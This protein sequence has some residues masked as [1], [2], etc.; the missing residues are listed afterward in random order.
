M[1]TF[2]SPVYTFEP[3]SSPIERNPWLKWA[4]IIGVW[5]FIGVVY[6]APIYIEMRAEGM[7]HSAFKVF[8]WGILIWVAWAPFEPA[9]VWFAR[10][11]SLLGGAWKRSLPVH[12]PVF[13]ISSAVHSAVAVAI[14]LTVKPWDNMGTTTFWPRFLSRMQ[15]SFAGD[16]LVYGGI[17]GV[18]YAIDYYRKYQERE[19][20]ATQLENQLALAQL[21]SLRM[22]LHPHFLFNTLNGI[23]GLVRD[24]KNDAAVSMLVGLSDLLRHTL[25]HSD[26]QEVEL[27]EEINFIKLYL[28]IQ[29]MR[30]SDRLQI[31]FNIDPATS[32]A[33]VPNL[34]LQPL[35]ENALR[36]GIGRSADAGAITVSSKRE[37]GSLLITVA[38][39]GEGLPYDW[40]L[41][42]GSGIGLANT[43]A[44]LQQLYGENHRFDIHNG[45]SG[46][47][48]VEIVMP[49]KI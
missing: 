40:Q 33:L 45:D 31:N 1:E 43:A 48:E 35:L 6:T 34:L 47:V 17:V 11:F 13:L 14:V 37:N 9:I 5:A 41:K 28:G 42:T 22:Q 25:E 23:V 32:K 8:T 29:Q 18:C 49:L 39:N 27:N 3:H 4:A 46:G 15:S 19:F 16:L 38:D 44:R 12:I 30:F 10:H 24:H 36:H 7:V 26:R 2:E 20:V 21:E